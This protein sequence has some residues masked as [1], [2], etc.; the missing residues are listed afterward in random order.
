MSQAIVRSLI[1]SAGLVFTLG[2]APGCGG[3]HH[4]DSASGGAASI[5][6]GPASGGAGPTT[7][8]SSGG[9][10]PTTTGSSGGAGPTTTGSSGGAG[11]TTAT[12]VGPDDPC[13]HMPH[14]GYLNDD[15]CLEPP[16]P[17]LGFQ[18]HLGPTDY[19]DPNDVGRFILPVGGEDKLCENFTTPNTESKYFVE[20]HTR[21][22]SG[23]HHMITYALSSAA[24]PAA[25]GT[26]GP[27]T[28]DPSTYHYVI[29]AQSALGPAGGKIDVPLAG[30]TAPE[31][32][33]IASKLDASTKAVVE[34]HYI[35]STEQDMLREAWINI[36]YADPSK[37]TGV[38]DPIFFIGGLGMNVAAHATQT[39]TESGCG[40]SANQG[41]DLRV[42]SVV[43]HTHAL[44]EHL[45]AY[46]DRLDG[47]HELIYQTNNW[48]ESLDAPF[49]SLRQNPAPGSP[50]V[51]G[52]HTGLL[53]LKRGETI[54]WQCDVNNTLDTAVVYADKAYTGEMCNLFGFVTPGLGTPWTCYK[55]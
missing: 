25:D 13:I 47:T 30:N 26:V 52:A 36:L 53:T 19:D 39:I 22:R 49:N 55:Q 28:M 27:C 38:R 31:D 41:A 42:L 12:P 11:P 23:T 54:S 51:D 43:G 29:G 10:G 33:G 21:L 40:M 16:S 37:I 24:S 17:D 32:A 14:T 20:Y 4:G 6:S 9:A 3:E 50:A 5:L 8:G 45:R 2:T 46:I 35:N 34:V 1:T 44:T 15:L 7:T 48:E 18:L